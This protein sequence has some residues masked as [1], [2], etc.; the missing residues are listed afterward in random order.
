[1]TSGSLL[2]LC[3]AVPVL[4]AAV[5]VLD[6]TGRLGRVLGL[7]VPAGLAAAGAALVW[8]T[9]DGQVVVAQVAGWPGGVAIPFVADVFSALLLALIGLLVVASMVFAR[10][11]GVT[12]DPLVAPM[13]L[14]LTAGVAGAFLTADLF[15]L[16]VMIEVALLPSYVLMAR[17][18]GPR[19]ARATRL[20]LTVNLSASTLLLA[21]LAA[22][23]GTAGTLNLAALAGRGS[24]PIVATAVGIVLVALAVKAALV[25]VHTWLPATYP[26]AAPA[27]TAL[28]SGLLTKVGVYALIRVV[29]L[30]YEPGP[31]LTAVVVAVAVVTMVVGVLGALGES[32]MRGVL[33][34]HMVSQAGYVLVGLGLAGAV[35]LA[36]GVF[37]MVQ[38]AAVKAALFLAIGAVEV[39]RRTGV[40]TELGGVASEHRWTALAFLLGALSLTGLPPFSGFWAKL[41]I[42]DAAAEAGSAVAFTAALV[43]SVGT[44]VSMLKLGAGVF[45]GARPAAADTAGVPTRGGGPTA[46][47]AQPSAG[48]VVLPAHDDRP[49]RDAR[50]SLLR[51]ARERGWSAGLVAPGVALALLSLAIGVYPQPMLALAQTAGQVLADPT[52]YVQGVLGR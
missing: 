10:A 5:A 18:G 42:L 26:H 52:A 38:Y 30:V 23:Y 34:F 24:E 40:I 48:S 28:F 33:A 7:V 37:Y 15:N 50:P 21:G 44:M 2:P 13:V 47:S 31:T 22:V 16:F 1:M 45:W 46:R 49:D 27:V 20:Y 12:A 36:A 32:T 11:S 9:R 41:G 4:A 6:R 35:G 14:V 43:V 29:T 19:A 8:A 17:T 51:Q 39:R 3:F 25:P